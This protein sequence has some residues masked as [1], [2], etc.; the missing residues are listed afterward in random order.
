MKFYNKRLDLTES[1]FEYLLKFIDFEKIAETFS[2]SPMMAR[3]L[4]NRDLVLQDEITRFL[5]GRMISMSSG[6]PG[7][8]GC[9]VAGDVCSISFVFIR[10]PLPGRCRGQEQLRAGARFQPDG[11]DV[12]APAR[13]SMEGQRNGATRHAR[14]PPRIAVAAGKQLVIEI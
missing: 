8:L 11:P 3:I 10:L 13:V 12:G 6:R 7:A 4:R 2:I 5:T 14:Q 9:S 1:E